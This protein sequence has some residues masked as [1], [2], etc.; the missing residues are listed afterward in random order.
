MHNLKMK[1]K[2]KTENTMIKTWALKKGMDAIYNTAL[3][4]FKEKNK[5]VNFTQN[6]FEKSISD[7]IADTMNWSKEISVR[8]LDKPKEIGNTYVHL[9]YYLTPKRYQFETNTEYPT[10]LKFKEYL[11]QTDKST[12]IL[13]QPGAGKTTSLKFIAYKVLTEEGFCENKFNL[14]IV[15][16]F[17]ELQQYGSSNF[18]KNE[19]IFDKIY[20][21][22]GLVGVEDF[23]EKNRWIVESIVLTALNELH[24]LLILDG[25]DEYPFDDKQ[26]VVQEIQTL[27]RALD[28]SKFILTSRT[29]EFPY[30]IEN[31]SQFEI[32]PLDD[33][34][35][36]EFSEYW[37]N[38]DTLNDIFY[39]Q[40]ISST[41]LD[42]ARRPLT[43]THLLIIFEKSKPKQIPSKPNLIYS[44]VIELL[45]REW[46]EERNIIRKS[47]Y[48]HFQYERKKSFL[49]RLSFY[50]T[51]KYYSASFSGNTIRSTYIDMCEAYDLPKEESYE[52]L[53]E[54]ESHN[55]LFIRSGE[56][57][58]EFAHKSIQEYFTAEYLRGTPVLSNN[59]IELSRIPNELA[60][61]VA[62]SFEPN[63]YFSTITNMMLSENLDADFFDTFL[64][65]LFLENPDFV[66]N[67]YLAFN[68]L[69]IYTSI[70]L[71]DRILDEILVK[72]SINEID[73]IVMNNNTVKNS[74]GRLEKYY[75][76]E[77]SSG[78]LIQEQTTIGAIK[79]KLD[80]TVELIPR[81]LQGDSN[82]Y[83]KKLIAK[84]KY[85]EDWTYISPLVRRIKSA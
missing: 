43:L 37:L 36:K 9:N 76:V 16:R 29:V 82:P 59:Q 52:V 44:K 77:E 61:L 6:D 58:F 49:C 26:K 56:S 66:T 2:P 3:K 27:A 35:I 70:A 65:R 39:N 28:T 19:G 33:A 67:P 21:I 22:L 85:I 68:V 12:I 15:I 80:D 1:E 24:V 25:F 13:G 71:D 55:G 41:Y 57:T 73:K 74:I 34:Q 38:D 75:T 50:L 14:P 18:K 42:T 5:Y 81:R 64:S 63:D 79:F 69:E 84:L 46:D 4:H 10:K 32:A 7:H 83:R 53:N 11:E 54:L 51:K 31:A 40:L 78:K 30:N 8:A 45:L 62:L 72:N 23:D 17:R 48:S 60:I 47:A 20:K